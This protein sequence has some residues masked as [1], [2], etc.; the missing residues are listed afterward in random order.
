MDLSLLILGP[1]VTEKTERLKMARTY[2]IKVRNEATKVDVKN[3]LTKFYGVS[4]ASVR[5]LRTTTKRRAT[6]AG[7]FMTKRHP[8]KRMLVTLTEKS[9]AL[10]F[11][12]F[13]VS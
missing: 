8:S 12:K 5:V 13:K 6:G 7:K 9:S 11:S 1:I 10:D 2:T 3:A 4:V